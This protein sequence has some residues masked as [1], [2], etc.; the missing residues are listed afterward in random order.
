MDRGEECGEYL[1]LTEVD[2]CMR[3]YE[4]LEV[5]ASI[6]RE[7]C[8][9]AVYNVYLYVYVLCI[10]DSLNVIYGNTIN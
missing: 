7:R 5:Q 10:W 9:I 3:Y 8:N 2:T 4:S 1:S 6:E